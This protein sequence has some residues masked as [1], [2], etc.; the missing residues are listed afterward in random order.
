MMPSDSRRPNSEI[1]WVIVVA[2]C[3]VALASLPYVVVY[4]TTP[5][6]LRFVGTL[7]NPFDGDSYLAK[8]QIGAQGGWLFHLPY[9]AQDHPA[10]CSFRFISC[11]ATL[12]RGRACRFRWCITWRASSQASSLL[13]VV[14]ALIARV[15]QD[16]AERR[17]AF[18]FVALSSGLGWLAVL[19]GHIWHI[20]FA[21]P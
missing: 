8:M 11:S 17:L 5:P 6:D 7:L 4:L 2:T 9:T 19:L 3:V 14:Y 20:R 10:R 15:T 12:Q 1:T 16:L 18:L 13:L 21:H